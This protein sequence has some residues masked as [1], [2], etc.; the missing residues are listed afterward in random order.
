[1]LA[2]HRGQHRAT[3][4]HHRAE[5]HREDGVP[6]G[7]LGAHHRTEGGGAGGRD[8]DVDASELSVGLLD[9]R[10]DGGILGDVGGDGEG[11]PAAL[12]DRRRGGRQLLPRP[13]REHDRGGFTRERHGDGVPDPAPGTSD[14]RDLPAERAPGG[15]QM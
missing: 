5:I 12:A 4:R 1:M 6:V 7:R 3:A 11:R 15:V 10:L 14:D 9:H 13:R 2:D 8:Q